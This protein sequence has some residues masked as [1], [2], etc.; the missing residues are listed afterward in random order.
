IDQNRTM[1]RFTI[2]GSCVP[3]GEFSAVKVE[4]TIEMLV[5][6]YNDIS[7]PSDQAHIDLDWGRKADGSW[8]RYSCA[9]SKF[10][11]F[12]SPQ[13]SGGAPNLFPYTLILEEGKGSGSGI[14]LA[15]G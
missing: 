9:V 7:V 8:K 2:L 13:D 11:A 1:L 12:L 10:T 4:E 14:S 15:G 6:S 3:Y 5:M